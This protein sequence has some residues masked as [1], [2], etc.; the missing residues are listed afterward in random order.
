VR[1]QFFAGFHRR[2]PAFAAAGNDLI[3]EHV[4]E[5]P[6]WRHDLAVLL[7]NL[8]VFLVGVHCDLDEL[9]RRERVRG[10]R[11]RG[12][13]RTHVQVDGDRP[14]WAVVPQRSLWADVDPPLPRSY[15]G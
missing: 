12:E 8:D 3:V 7:A 10:D 1:P 9:D 6:A 15:R 11:R 13:G 2:L 14:P 4:I 5:S